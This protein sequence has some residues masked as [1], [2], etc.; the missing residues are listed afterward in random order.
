[1]HRV[2]DAELAES[3]IHLELNLSS[4][5]FEIAVAPPQS[6]MMTASV[7]VGGITWWWQ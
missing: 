7:L 4:R 6:A 5:V 3:R 2:D 1:M